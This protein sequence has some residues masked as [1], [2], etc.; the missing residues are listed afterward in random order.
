M[1]CDLVNVSI[2]FYNWCL[3]GQKQ[4]VLKVVVEYL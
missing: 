3:T 4:R 1:N 2:G